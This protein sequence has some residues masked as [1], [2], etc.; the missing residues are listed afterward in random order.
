MLQLSFD[1]GGSTSNSLYSTWDNQFY[2]G[3]ESWLLRVNCDPNGGMEVDRDFFVDLHDRPGGLARAHEVRLQGGD[4]TT[5]IFPCD[6]R[7]PRGEHLILLLG[8]GAGWRRP[9]APRSVADA[10]RPHGRP[11]EEAVMVVE[12]RTAAEAAIV[13]A[14]LDYFEGWFGDAYRMERA[15]HAGLAKRSLDKDGRR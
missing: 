7:P 3:L 4:C 6:R 14:V 2:P 15:L 13:D 1:G 12:E 5:E 10:V 8:W 9:G 11:D